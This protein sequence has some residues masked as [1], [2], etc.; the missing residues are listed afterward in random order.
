MFMFTITVFMLARDPGRR[1]GSYGM[2]AASSTLMS[3]NHA[4][5]GIVGL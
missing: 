3:L 1:R 2:I 4:V 5:S